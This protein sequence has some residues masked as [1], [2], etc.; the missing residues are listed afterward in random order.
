FS[1]EVLGERPM[2]QNKQALRVVAKESGFEEVILRPLSARLLPETAPEHDGRVNRERLLAIK[3][4]SR[5]PQMDLVQK[6]GIATYPNPA[7][8]CRLT[9]PGYSKRL[10]DLFDHTQ[11]VSRRDLDLLSTGRHFRLP[12]NI[13][14]IIGR[15]RIENDLLEEQAGELDLL[16][17]V[18]DI[19]G[20]TVLIPGGSNDETLKF[21]AA[22][23][24][25]Y[26]DAPAEDQVT[27][28]IAQNNATIRS[29]T[30]TACDQEVLQELVI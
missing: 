18:D 27:V 20:P 2:S 16:L 25:R 11:D 28:T 22:A 15:N 24:A 7:G 10:R 9:D 30:A 21:A 14:M 4:R 29:V 19:P 17:T 12:G 6:F 23:C 8:G 26:S 13:K 5:K 3:G 1:G